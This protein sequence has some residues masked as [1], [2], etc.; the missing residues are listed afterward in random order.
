MTGVISTLIRVKFRSSPEGI[1]YLVMHLRG[2]KLF[3]IYW[4]GGKVKP[5]SLGSGFAGQMATSLRSGSSWDTET[6]CFLCTQEVA[7]FYLMI[8]ILSLEAVLLQSEGEF[9]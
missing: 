5:F 2:T 8:Y 9:H 6:G 4:E 3:N 1:N 7:R